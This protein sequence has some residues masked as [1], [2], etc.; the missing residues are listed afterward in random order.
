MFQTEFNLIDTSFAHDQYAVAGVQSTYLKWNRDQ[1][2]NNAPT[3]FTH[4][5]MLTSSIERVP[6]EQRYGLLFESQSI[7]PRVYAQVPGVMHK[8]KTVF[9]H[10]S[11][12]LA[13]FENANWIP[14][15]GIWV[16]G[17][18]GGGAIALGP[19]SKNTSMLSSNKFR[20]RLHRKR[21]R[22]ALRLTDPQSGVDVFRPKFLNGKGFQVF[23]T[24]NDYRY[25]IVMEN[26]ID[27][28]YFTEKVLNCFATGTI[29]V[30]LGA[31]NIGDFFD[32]AGIVTFTNSRDLRTQVLPRL[33]AK[34]YQLA[35]TAIK[36]NFELAQSYRSLEDSITTRYF[37]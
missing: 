16:G 10:S 30:Y 28:S 2:A 8:F 6:I 5:Q 37:M 25:S 32:S 7:I 27:D 15:G 12:L 11:R 9:T 26:F 36:T 34:H 19:K 17:S 1:T 14:G 31:R 18:N 24:L 22:L 23:E 35:Q 33:G 3:F 21:L 20:T 4:E 29:P 13:E